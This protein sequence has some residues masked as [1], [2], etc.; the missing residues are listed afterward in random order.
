LTILEHETKGHYYCGTQYWA[1][2]FI[3]AKRRFDT[4]LSIVELVLDTRLSHWIEG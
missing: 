1:N 3:Q 2:E 4:A